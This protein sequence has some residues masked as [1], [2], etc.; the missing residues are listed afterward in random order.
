MARP[1]LH[2][3]ARALTA[4]LAELLA[5]TGARA[6]RV[7]DGR[8][9]AVLAAALD[10]AAVDDRTPDPG[11]EP[12]TLAGL[13][14]DAVSGGS[15][16]GG[17]G[18]GG[19]GSPGSGSP[20]AGGVDD[21]V[22]RTGRSVHLLRPVSVAFVHLRLAAGVPDHEIA[23]V[24]RALSAPRLVTAVHGALHA[25]APP[26]NGLVGVPDLPH[27][28]GRSGELPR[29]QPL[30][31]PAGH[32]RPGGSGRSGERAGGGRVWPA[33]DHRGVRAGWAAGPGPVGSGPVGSGPARPDPARPDPARAA[34]RS[35][36]DPARSVPAPR[37]GSA[38]RAAAVDPFVPAPD[39]GPDRR[40]R[41]AR[42]PAPAQQPALAALAVAGVRPRAGALASVAL[43]ELTEAALPRRRRGAMTPALAAA[44]GRPTG[45]PERAWA[46]D[47]DTL[48]RLAAGLRRLS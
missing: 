35:L 1:A 25:Q 8:T 5:A 23:A 21:V 14:R 7:V 32:S 3:P 20:D 26:R 12:G 36:P 22:V 33:G 43:A 48:R 40:S 4:V 2:L 13:L 47:L 27:P 44:G 38:A 46:R 31:R 15:G 42:G 17:S 28:R 18:S 37:R 9:G 19:S 10:D 6:V 34:A 24:R 41:P 11:D 30:V 16:S 39:P 29:S 45:L